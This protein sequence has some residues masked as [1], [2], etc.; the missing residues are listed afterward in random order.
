[1]KSLRES[2]R[3][4]ELPEELLRLAEEGISMA[5]VLLGEEIFLA[6]QGV[7]WS[8][9]TAA[10]MNSL[11]WRLLGRALIGNLEAGNVPLLDEDDDMAAE[12]SNDLARW[13][14]SQLKKGKESPKVSLYAGGR[15]S[16][17]TRRAKVV[18]WAQDVR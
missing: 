12:M 2:L 7:T 14:Q 16:D 13:I 10:G 3:D 4:A 18:K 17:E 11:M 9:E 6:G 5:P 8:W 15:V 1:M